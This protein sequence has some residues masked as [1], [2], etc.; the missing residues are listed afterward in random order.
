MS[1]SAFFFLLLSLRLLHIVAVLLFVGNAALGPYRRRQARLTGDFKI[2]AATYEI[3]SRSGRAITVPW[4]LTAVISGIALALL[5]GVPILQTGWIVWALVLVIV[6]VLLFIFCIA[7]LQAQATAAAL[8]AAKGDSPEQRA[9]FS[10]VASQL[11]PF[12]HLAHFIFL[13]ILA[14]MVFR[15]PLPLAW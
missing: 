2:I 6:V 12:S 10:R 4:F 11:E 1:L 8:A 9:T 13:L 7:P 5:S 14:L 3:H 15:P